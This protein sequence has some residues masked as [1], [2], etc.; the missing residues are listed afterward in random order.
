[1]VINILDP[2]D[3]LH[4]ES[5][6][7]TALRILNIAFEVSGRRICEFPSLCTLVLDHGCKF[8]FQLARS[9]S[10]AVLQTSLR[11][12]ATMFEAMRTELKLQQELF[13]AFTVDRLAPPIPKQPPALGRKASSRGGAQSPD[14]DAE[15]VPSTPRVL[16]APARGDTRELLLETLGHISRH[17]S[18]M[19]DLY[20]NYDCDM[21]CENMFERLIEFSTKVCYFFPKCSL[22]LIDIIAIIRAC[23]HHKLAVMNSSHGSSI[24]SICIWISC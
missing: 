2:N 7:L 22:N 4:T 9:D 6:R 3:Q 14:L 18:F 19:V 20:T 23:I 21:N 17:S 16:A 13:L 11:T 24:R 8:L 10:S 15:K 5:T 1:M 12:I